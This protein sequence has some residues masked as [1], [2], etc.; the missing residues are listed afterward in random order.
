MIEWLNSLLRKF[1][2]EINFQREEK[3]PTLR[4]KMNSLEEEHRIKT[5]TQKT[6]GTLIE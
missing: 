6:W 2:Y 1:G 3:H 4:E 5:R